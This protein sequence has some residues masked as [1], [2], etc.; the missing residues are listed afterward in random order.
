MLIELGCRTVQSLIE[1]LLF[2][3]T[4]HWPILHYYNFV[5][6]RVVCIYYI[7]NVLFNKVSLFIYNHVAYYSLRLVKTKTQDNIIS[8]RSIHRWLH[9]W[10]VHSFLLLKGFYSMDVLTCLFV[11]SAVKGHLGC[12]QFLLITH[13][14]AMNIMEKFCVNIHFQDSRINTPDCDWW[15]RS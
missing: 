12:L 6:L 8:L 3:L 1:T 10:I 11:H 13:K 14:A 2:P 5:T 7:H 15:V 9:P 4:N